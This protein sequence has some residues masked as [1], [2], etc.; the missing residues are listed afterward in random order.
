MRR[1]FTMQCYMLTGVEVLQ[2]CAV[3]QLRYSSELAAWVSEHYRLYQQVATHTASVH[4]T[5]LRR[6]F[7]VDLIKPVSNVRLS[8]KSYIDFSEIWHVGR[9]R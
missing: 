5:F 9:G 2:F 1:R 8:T 3:Y 7:R 6:L 4:V